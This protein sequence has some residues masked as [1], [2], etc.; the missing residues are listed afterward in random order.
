MWRIKEFDDIVELVSAR[1]LG[2]SLSMMENYFLTHPQLSGRDALLAVRSDYLLLMDYWKKGFDDPQR[3]TL[4]EQLLRHMYVVVADALL[5]H[6]L[7][8]LPSLSSLHRAARQTRNDWSVASVKEVL[9]AYV[10]DTALLELEQPHIRQQKAER[11]YADH[12]QFMGG[13]FNHLCTSRQWT[14]SYARAVEDMLFSPTIDAHDQQHMLS[15]ITIAAMNIFDMNKFNVLV[16][17]YENTTDEP[18]RQRA[19]V[20][21][22]FALDAAKAR[23]YPELA[24]TVQRLCSSEQCRKELTELQI[25]IVYC[26]AADND[27]RLIKDEIMPDL[28][29]GNNMQFTRQ[30]LVEMEEDQLENIL[31]PDTAERNMEQME[32][33]MRR[34]ADMQRRGSD[35]YFSGFSQMKRFPF[36]SKLSNWFLPFNPLHP[37]ITQIWN[38]KKGNKFLKAITYLGAFCD[39]DKYSFILAFNE[40]LSHLPEK[41]LQMIDDGEVSP[42][43]VGGEVS[44]KEQHQPAFMRRAYLQNLYRFYRIFPQRSD[45]CNPFEP[46]T[47]LF[48]RNSIFKETALEHAMTE[49]AAFLIK[50][51]MHQEAFAV[52]NN[53]GEKNRNAEYYIMTGNLQMRLSASATEHSMKAS[54]A[55]SKAL[56]LLDIDDTDGLLR[57]KAL[58]GYARALFTEERFSEALAAY[59]KLLALT[60]D[61]RNVLLNTAVCMIN[62]KE[63]DEALKILF[64]LNYENEADTAV[65]R[66]FA[67]ALALSGKYEQATKIYNQLLSAEQRNASDLLNYGYCLWFQRDI[68]GALSLFR[69][70]AEVEAVAL[71]EQ[72]FRMSEQSLLHEH[73]IGDTEI[74]LMLDAVNGL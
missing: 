69:Q 38:Q 22:V 59:Q 24:E 13:L 61:N 62:L 31:H 7:V 70:Y 26:M 12:Q 15:A 71:L 25:Q 45:F 58:K 37:E 19:L 21:W 17:I 67:W 36:F 40:V 28:M 29:K 9:E 6:Q 39:S 10:S 23:I 16:H 4:Y 14:D 50:Q 41:M 8:Q 44:V 72:D 68:A 64:R 35:I 18:L 3:N 5:Q 20:G 11:I 57:E 33:S 47:A 53:M 56:A 46:S 30:G 48:F 34:M 52:L 73:G 1:R 49:I 27:S 66:V 42:M 2:D 65:N 51:K 63:Y 54:E 55:Y 60:P 32:A 74:Q 43:A